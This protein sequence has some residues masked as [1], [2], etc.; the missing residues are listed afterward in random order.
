MEKARVEIPEPPSK[1]IPSVAITIY[2]AIASRGNYRNGRGVGHI[3]TAEREAAHS[4]QTGK[5]DCA[6]AESRT[7]VRKPT[8]NPVFA[9]QMGRRVGIK[10]PYSTTATSAT[11]QSRDP[12]A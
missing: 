11:E 8:E 4:S 6:T 2:P 7:T 10:S 12:G 9:Q 3:T 5:L 1:Q